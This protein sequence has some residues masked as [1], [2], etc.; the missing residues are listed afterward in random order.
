MRTGGPKG[1]NRTELISSSTHLAAT[2]GGQGGGPKGPRSIERS[3]GPPVLLGAIRKETG[4]S[5]LI[6]PGQVE[7][8][9]AAVLAPSSP[10]NSSGLSSLED[11][12]GRAAVLT[13]SPVR[14]SNGRSLVFE[15]EAERSDF[16]ERAA[17]R[18]FDGG[19]SRPAAERLAAMDIIAQRSA[20]AAH[21]LPQLA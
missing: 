5:G 3:S 8:Q 16:W 1:P 10:P 20:R 21:T 12:G 2:Q 17:I 6:S 7:D 19:L 4:V 14:R 18:E 9:K 11:Q 15:S 13:A